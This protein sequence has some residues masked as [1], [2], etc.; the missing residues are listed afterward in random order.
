MNLN[1]CEVWVLIRFSKA[2][3]SWD[4]IFPSSLQSEPDSK[5]FLLAHTLQAVAYGWKNEEN[6][7][8]LVH[9]TGGRILCHTM[10]V[11]ES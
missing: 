2:Q 3:N 4:L 9:W 11:P 8:R 5:W 7:Y 6:S 1:E 10:Q